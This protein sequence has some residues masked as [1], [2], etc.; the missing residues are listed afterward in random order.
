M[1]R[2]GGGVVRRGG[3]SGKIYIDDEGVRGGQAKSYFQWRGGRGVRQKIIFDDKG[4]RDHKNY[5]IIAILQPKNR[6]IWGLNSM[7]PFPQDE[8]LYIVIQNEY[9]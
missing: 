1:H 6:E 5:D 9:R 2:G 3:C 4:G 8:C 7:N